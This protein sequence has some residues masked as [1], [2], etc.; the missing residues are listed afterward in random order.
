MRSAI[1]LL[2]WAPVLCLSGC[3]RTPAALISRQISILDETGETLATITDEASAKA[4]TEKLG[5]LQQEFNALVPDIKALDLTDAAKESLEDEHR[6]E[7]NRAL[8]KYQTELVRVRE[9]DLKVGGLSE[10]EEA[11][12]E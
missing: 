11:I 9:L 1:V 8:E 2:V 10:L 6:D 7:M 5:K 4:A 12:A 3:G